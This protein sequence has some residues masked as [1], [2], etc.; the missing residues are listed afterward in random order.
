MA[1]HLINEGALTEFEILQ[2]ASFRYA[3]IIAEWNQTVTDRLK[4][5]ALN[6]LSKCNVA[7]N[8]IR[9]LNVPGSF[10]LSLTA[11]WALEREYDTAICLGCIIKGETMHDKIIAQAVSQGI[12]DLNLQFGKPVVF[13]VLTVDNIHQ[14]FERS[15]GNFGNK[16]A[17]AVI[18]AIKMLALKSQL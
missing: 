6:V 3:L 12:M 4:G 14:A 17:E 11:K 16:G 5:G 18:T 2:A 15:G 7:D 10:E 1:G 8:H 13:G 9:I